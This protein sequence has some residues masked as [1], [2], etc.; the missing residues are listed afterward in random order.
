[1]SEIVAKQIAP[2]DEEIL[3]E[4]IRV[5]DDKHILGVGVTR[6]L[7]DEWPWQVGVYVAEYIREDPLQSEL[8]DSITG[9]LSALPGVVQAVHEDREHWAVQGDVNGEEL[10]G[11]C[12]AV[13]DRF[14]ER[15]GAAY[16]ALG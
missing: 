12:A 11:A 5:T 7:G 3:E 13:L 4:W 10:I 8:H 16:K 15:T 9:A 1:M 6:M 2:Q 14:A